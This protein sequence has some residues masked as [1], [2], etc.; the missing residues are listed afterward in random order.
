[1]PTDVARSRRT[2]G[3][4]EVVRRR[5]PALGERRE[6]APSLSDNGGIVAPLRTP[7]RTRHRRRLAAWALGCALGSSPVH[8]LADAARNRPPAEPGEREIAVAPLPSTTR[9]GA[10]TVTLTEPADPEERAL[11][12]SG[13]PLLAMTVTRPGRP[14]LG[15]TTIQ[16]LWMYGRVE[17]A[18][19]PRFSSWSKTGVSNLV[20]CRLAWA[21]AAGRYCAVW[22]QDYES[23]GTGLVAT[24]TRRENLPCR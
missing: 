23:T 18:G 2:E 14:P 22:C 17:D 19:P 1:M 12:G 3:Q 13:G 9:L 6:D 11:G 4:R 7:A 16:S 15:P 8:L 24:G 21:P 20:K 10:Y 5:I